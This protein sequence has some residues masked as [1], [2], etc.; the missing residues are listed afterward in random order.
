M[1]RTLFFTIALVFITSLSFSQTKV[2]IINLEEY[3]GAMFKIDDD[4]PYSRSEERR[5]GKGC[6]PGGRRYH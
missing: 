6:K 1:K 4:K 5:V 2:N 3:N